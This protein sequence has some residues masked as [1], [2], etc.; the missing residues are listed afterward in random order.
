MAVSGISLAASAHVSSQQAAS[1]SSR[2]RQNG[3]RTPSMTDI[4]AQGSSVASA[5]SATGKI[6]SRINITA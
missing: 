3:Q 4:D 5:P 1:T 2:H 6:G